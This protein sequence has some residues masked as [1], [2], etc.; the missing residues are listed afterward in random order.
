MLVNAANLDTLRVGFKTN[1]QNGLG[2]APTD[3][4][5]FEPHSREGFWLCFFKIIIRGNHHQKRMTINV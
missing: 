5:Q 2:Q 3:I 1:F 4:H